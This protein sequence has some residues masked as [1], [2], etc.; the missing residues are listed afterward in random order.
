MRLI[1]EERVD[2]LHTNGTLID[3]LTGHLSSL[4]TDKP[5]VTTLHG[6]RPAP[7]SVP[8]RPWELP[9]YLSE[10]AG[11][12]LE[13]FWEPRTLNQFVAVSDAVRENWRSYLDALGAPPDRVRVIYSGVPVERFADPDQ[14]AIA[15][16]KREL[17][18][19]SGPVLISVGRFHRGKNL[20]VLPD[21]VALLKSMHPGTQLLMVGDGD[22]EESLRAQ[23]AR[24]GLEDSVHFLGLRTDVEVLFGVA[25]MFLFPSG[26][27]GFG[28]VVIEALA[29]GLPVVTTRLPSLEKLWS[30]DL[31]IELADAISPEAFAAAAER[32]AADIDG[33]KAKAAAGQSAVRDEW[34][35]ASSAAKYLELYREIRDQPRGFRR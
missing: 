22:E 15:R 10:K 25:D 20:H 4:A 2:V 24:L 32:I 23:V 12:H 27:E 11:R 26:Q 18:L 33:A 31:G 29:A 6:V 1:D 7:F 8:N 28:L 5:M 16:T 14:G 19:H 21:V 17:R 30:R 9:E 35:A 3:K 13:R 34:S